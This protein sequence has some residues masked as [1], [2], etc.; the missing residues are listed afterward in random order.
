MK[1]TAE[2]TVRELLETVGVQVDG[3]RPWDIQVHDPRFYG[4]VLAGGSLYL[5]EA[6]M[7]GAWDVERIDQFCERL[8]EGQLEER[9]KQS[10]RTIMLAIWWR[11]M[12]P[13]ARRRAFKIGKQH[14]DLGNDLFERML[15]PRMVYSCGYWAE[16]STLAKAQEAKLDLICRKLQLEPGM[17]LLD[18]GCGWGSLL[19]YAAERYGIEG[20]GVTVSEQQAT[21][22]EERCKGLP[23]RI[24]LSDYRDLT[25][26][27]DRI[28]SV[29]MV[30]HVGHKNYPTFMRTAYRCIKPGGLFL[31]HTI[32]NNR[33]V[34]SG[35]PWI[36][37]YI[38]PNSMLPSLAQLAEAAE[39][40]FFVEDLHSFGPYY[41]NTLMAWD[42]NFREHWPE[43][44]DRYGERFYRMWRFFLNSCAA[45]FRTR[46]IQLWQILLARAPRPRPLAVPRTTRP[47]AAAHRGAASAQVSPAQA[48]PAQA[49]EAPQGSKD[50]T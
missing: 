5:G 46:R 13:Q 14:Y 20:V 43:I 50:S 49:A 10:L 27:F 3:K 15:D 16:A 47:A 48:A 1:S 30:E 37:K 39:S 2:R 8:F 26:E 18:I 42:Y 40:R 33:S 36:E 6:Y 32:G 35:D 38:F 24:E 44:A 9:A 28:A 7:D 41:D 12:N 25:G 4:R 22:A 34:S 29:G 19:Q 23:V 45:A 11:I 21:A 17:R 31:L